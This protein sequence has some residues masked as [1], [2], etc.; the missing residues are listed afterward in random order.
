MSLMSFCCRPTGISPDPSI[1]INFT[2]NKVYA[3]CNGRELSINLQRQA[4]KRNL[5]VV[6]G[7]LTRVKQRGA[8]ARYRISEEV[9][10]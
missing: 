1:S 6:P 4:N 5:L 2:K 10:E 9:T 3:L 8:A 7:N